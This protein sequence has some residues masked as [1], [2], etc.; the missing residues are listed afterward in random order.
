MKEAVQ[1]ENLTDEA[2]AEKGFGNHDRGVFC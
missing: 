1:Q 2:N